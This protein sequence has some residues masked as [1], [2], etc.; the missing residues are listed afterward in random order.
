M[1]TSGM[2]YKILDER[3][4]LLECLAVSGIGEVYRGRDLE[5]AQSET[6]SSRILIHLLPSQ[7]KLANFE[8]S[9]Q[10]AQQLTQELNHPWILAILDQGQVD[11]RYYFVLQSPEG[12]GAHSLMSL[13]SYQLPPL[14][15]LMQQFGGL[16]KAKHLPEILDSSLLITLP[17]QSLYLLAT[18]FIQPLHALRANHTGISIFKRLNLKPTFALTGMMVIALSTFAVEYQNHT[19][20]ADLLQTPTTDLSSPQ[21]LLD[22]AEANLHDRPVQAQTAVLPLI[23]QEPLPNLEPTLVALQSSKVGTTESQ[24]QLRNQTNPQTASLGKLELVELGSNKEKTQT[25]AKF[26]ANL[27]EDKANL[28]AKTKE[29]PN[30]VVHKS[31]MLLEVNK[32]HVLTEFMGKD[33]G[34]YYTASVAT[35]PTTK[36]QPQKNLTSPS[37]APSIDYLAEL[38]NRSLEMGNFSQKNGVLFYARRIK[39]RDRLH[40]Q[41]ERLARFIVQH[42]HKQARNMLKTDAPAQQVSPLLN[43]SKN[44]IQEF[45]LKSLNSA[46]EMLEHKFNQYN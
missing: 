37:K 20:S 41:V 28:A 9:T 2:G 45:N 23:F 5:L 17:N 8:A 35:L 10:H 1:N 44:L 16:V 24:A 34:L 30:S 6:A 22:Q 7:Y 38:A 13:P 40:P 27:I 39:I 21:T 42:Q 36:A 4:A 33:G 46:Q 3:Y 18:A 31:S 25:N 32:T 11:G 12:L 14:S 43:T 29:T 19:E 26:V 15:K